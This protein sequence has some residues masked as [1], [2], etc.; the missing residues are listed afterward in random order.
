[1]KTLL[2]PASSINVKE[3]RLQTAH[4]PGQGAQCLQEIWEVQK[5]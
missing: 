1:M 2:K 3:I 5:E 4:F